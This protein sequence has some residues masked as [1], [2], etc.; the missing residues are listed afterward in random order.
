M[1]KGRDRPIVP[2]DC[3]DHRLNI[4]IG[5]RGQVRLRSVKSQLAGQGDGQVQDDH[6]VSLRLK[7]ACHRCRTLCAIAGQQYGLGSRLGR[8]QGV[9]TGKRLPGHFVAADGAQV[10]PIESGRGP[11]TTPYRIQFGDRPFPFFERWK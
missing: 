5:N 11:R 2:S 4:L 10:T 6:P 1:H 9:R 3:M 7:L 8:Y